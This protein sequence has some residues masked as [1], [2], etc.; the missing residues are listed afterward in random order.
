[1][2]DPKI[3]NSAHKHGIADTDILHAYHNNYKGFYLSDLIMLI[4]P[5][6]NGNLL[7]LGVNREKM[8]DSI[9]HAMKARRKFT[10]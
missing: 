10:R 2:L 5:D 4:G 6:R 9:V 3:L 8:A 1:M 7:E